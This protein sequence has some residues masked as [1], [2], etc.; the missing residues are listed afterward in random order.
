MGCEFLSSIFLMWDTEVEN[1]PTACI[2]Y[3]IITI[4]MEMDLVCLLPH[5]L[6]GHGTFLSNAP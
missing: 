2:F 5:H 3:T 6:E 1:G 4:Q